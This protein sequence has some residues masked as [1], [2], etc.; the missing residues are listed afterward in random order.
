MKDVTVTVRVSRKLK[1]ELAKYG[2]NVSEVLRRAL[3]EEVKKRKREELKAIAS[4]LGEF[5]SKISDEE[6]VKSI[7]EMR[8]KR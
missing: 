5:F 6:I 3:E 4:D 7:R 2:V 8:E 1:G